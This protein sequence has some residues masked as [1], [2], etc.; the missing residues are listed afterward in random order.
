[1]KKF[2]LIHRAIELGWIHRSPAPEIK[3]DSYLRRETR[4]QWHARG[5]NSSG[6]PRRNQPRPELT[7]LDRKTYHREYMRKWRATAETP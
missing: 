1:M 4:A 3:I 6:H 2:E 7:G 5:L